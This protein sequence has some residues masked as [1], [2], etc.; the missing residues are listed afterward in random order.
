MSNP[1][2]D[3]TRRIKALLEF[4]RDACIGAGMPAEIYRGTTYQG[5]AAV[6]PALLVQSQGAPCAV[7]CYAGSE[8]ANKPRRTAGV[9]V[10][11]LQGH[12]RAVPGTLD[13]IG[14]AELVIEALD[15]VIYQDVEGDYPIT[16]KWRVVSD[17]VV[18][19]DGLD[20]AACVIVTF[21]VEDY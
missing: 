1:V 18:D 14:G 21:N 17:E 3:T 4:A 15:D 12:T 5:L 16:E 11:V 2:T 13:A 8:Y 7:V 9:S 6:I 10:L 19:I 20:A